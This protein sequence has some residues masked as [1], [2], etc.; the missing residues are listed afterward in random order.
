MFYGKFEEY[1]NKTPAI[2]LKKAKNNI[3]ARKN[4]GATGLKLG[5][6][7]QLDSGSNMGWVPPLSLGM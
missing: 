7:T 5:I 2:G 3:L 6:H 1:W 4:E